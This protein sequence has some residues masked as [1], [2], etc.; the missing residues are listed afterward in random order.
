[1]NFKLT[2]RVTDAFGSICSIACI[3]IACVECTTGIPVEV[4]SLAGIAAG[5]IVAE[6]WSKYDLISIQKQ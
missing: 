5:K 4:I 2:G 6:I 3:T 1:M